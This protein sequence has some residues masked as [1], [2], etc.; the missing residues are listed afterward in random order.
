MKFP[1]RWGQKQKQMK[2]VMIAVLTLLLYAG[3]MAQSKVKG[4]VTEKNV[5]SPVI[6]ATIRMP[7]GKTVLSDSN[8]YFTLQTRVQGEITLEVSAVGFKTY[9]GKFSAAQETWEISLERKTLLMEPVE[10]R[11]VRA[12]DP[13]PFSKTTLSS[14]AIQQQNLGQDLPFILNQTPSVVVNADAGN[15]IGY[16][17]IRIRG[18]DP[19]RINMTINGIPYNDA[20]SQGV[21]FVNLPDLAS[22]SNSIQVQRGVGTSSNGSGAFGATLN[23]LTNEIMED[24]YAEL[25]NSYGSFNTWKNTFLAGTGLI[26]DHF[27]FDARLSRIISD[28][29]IDRAQTNLQSFF[30][31]GAWLSNKSSVRLN[32]FS[33]K[34][35]TYQ[36][37]N[38]VPESLLETDR[39]FNSAGTDK[40][41]PPYD[42]ET[43]NY[44][45]THYQLFYN[46]ALN[47]SWNLNL[48]MFYTKGAGYYEQYKSGQSYADYGMENPVY[49][50]DTLYVTDLIRQLWLDNQFFGNTFSLQYK[51][52]STDIIIGGGWS[53][54]LGNHFG[55]VVWAS[56]GFPDN[57]RWYDLDAN[58]T[59]LN[60]YG[61]WQQKISDRISLFTDLQL[62]KVDYNIYGFR[63][64]PTITTK[65]DWLFFNPKIGIS[66]SHNEWRS[67]ASVAVANKEPNR[68]DFEAGKDVQPSA[69]TL[70][71]LEAGIEKRNFI[72]SWGAT[73]YYMKYRNQLVLTGQI[74][75]VGAY[76]RTNI[77][78]S[79]RT[80]LE[81]TGRWKPLN[82][83]DVSG[84]LAFS[85][86]KVLDYTSYYDDYDLGGQKSEHFSK[87][88]IS[89]SP[90]TVAGYTANTRPFSRL[91]FS[92]IGKYVSR[93]YLDNTSRMER[94]LDPFYTQDLRLSYRINPR[95]MKEILLVGQ[96]INIFNTRFEPN[97][98]TYS[99]YYGGSL[100]TENFYYP[101][102]GINFMFALNC[103]F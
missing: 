8:G 28:G 33:G 89:F 79:Y 2:K 15:G 55:D 65:N 66:F 74:N 7:D 35:K 27:T 95:F 91:E 1:V 16:T 23:L 71:D 30:I 64:N 82:W 32:V 50:N 94:S 40:P 53:R 92:L 85:S 90:S 13:S 21:F 84:N 19:T 93:Q 6:N 38:G 78:N 11:A 12:S 59:D 86:N 36:A 101:M 81:L 72:F 73:F 42:N 18:S 31:S 77:P 34:E 22:S 70:Y 14:A 24:T 68:D 25:N 62:R 51:K 4:Q 60:I 100:Q 80:G 43:D 48:A 26:N 10:I 44:T 29:Y 102:A 67:Y 47:P 46:Q 56:V 17:S 87:S 5:A 41:G 39:T 20:E 52:P 49:G 54:Y 9:S 88:D 58:K 63:N 83:V 61:K 97:G 3:S 96:A 76:T 99:Y 69:E 103:K 98:Y 37:W 75:D 45:Q 57:Y